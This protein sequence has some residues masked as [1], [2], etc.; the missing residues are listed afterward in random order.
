[1]ALPVRLHENN[2][3][4]TKSTATNYPECHC[5]SCRKESEVEARPAAEKLQPKWRDPFNLRDHIAAC[6]NQAQREVSSCH[7]Q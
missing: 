6:P 1:M 3:D 4:V 7:A 5:A 2:K